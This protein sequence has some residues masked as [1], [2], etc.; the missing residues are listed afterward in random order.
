MIVWLLVYLAISAIVLPFTLILLSVNKTEA[1]YDAL[2][3]LMINESEIE[4]SELA[5]LKSQHVLTH[6]HTP[7]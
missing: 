1:D 3:L 5:T 7:C 2:A 4:T 6:S